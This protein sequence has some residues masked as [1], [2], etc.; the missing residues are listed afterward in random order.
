MHRQEQQQDSGAEGQAAG[1]PGPPAIGSPRHQRRSIAR[2][3]IGHQ[4]PGG[5]PQVAQQGRAE[6]PFCGEQP[7]ALVQGGGVGLKRRRLQ[8]GQAY[9]GQVQQ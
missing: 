2:L 6:Q 3:A 7:G 1:R 4:L 8:Q 5:Q 9:P